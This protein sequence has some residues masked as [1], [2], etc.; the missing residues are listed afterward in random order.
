MTQFTYGWADLDASN[1][2]HYGRGKPRELADA[3]FECNLAWTRYE[4]LVDLYYGPNYGDEATSEL[5]R[6]AKAKA[7][8]AAEVVKQLNIKYG[9]QKPDAHL[10]AAYDDKTNIEF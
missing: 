6:E 10:E 7:E 5:C 3:E 4:T 2:K 9:Y 1:A 8:A